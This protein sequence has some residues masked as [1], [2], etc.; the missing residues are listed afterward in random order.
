MPIL[1]IF[2][3]SFPL[4]FFLLEILRALN[5]HTYF[6]NVNLETV[7]WA[8]FFKS[9]I[10]VWEM[11]HLMTQRVIFFLIAVFILFAFQCL[12]R[13]RKVNCYLNFK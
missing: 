4:V 5:V 9:K 7:N 3:N 1:I 12:Q 2:E 10:Q 6:K 11:L 13:I 8:F